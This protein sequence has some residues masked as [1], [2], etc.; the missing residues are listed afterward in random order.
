MA[1]KRMFA[2]DL[3]T[4]DN[5]TDMS[6]SAQALYFHLSLQADDDGFVVNPKR[7]RTMIGASE[8]DY[9]ILIAKG[10]LIKFDSGVIVVTHWRHNNYLRKDRYKPSALPERNEL[11]IAPGGVYTLNSSSGIPMVDHGLT[12]YSIDK[13]SID[14]TYDD[15]DDMLTNLK[16]KLDYNYI[17]SQVDIIKRDILEDVIMDIVDVYNNRNNIISINQRESYPADYVRQR[18]SRLDR[19]LVLLI[20]DKLADANIGANASSYIRT[21]IFNTVKDY[22][23]GYNSDARHGR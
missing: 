4:S 14:K 15:D 5:F 17:I 16:I 21:T 19:E 6:L 8:D 9:K 3:V 12:Q 11:Y 2:K 22:N 20:I 7:I 1:D 23:T 18:Y 10:Y 13:I